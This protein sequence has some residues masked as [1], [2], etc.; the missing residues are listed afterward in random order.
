[1]DDFWK[2]YDSF[3]L[4]DCRECGSVRRCDFYDASTAHVFF[5]DMR[6][7]ITRGD[8][9]ERFRSSAAEMTLAELIGRVWPTV[10]DCDR[11]TMTQWGKLRDAS[12]ILRA[13]SFQGT[14]EDLKR[15]FDLLGHDSSQTLSIGELVRAR[16]LTRDESE[17]L[18]Q[19]WYKAFT[20][21]KHD[22]DS[23]S[24]SESG[25]NAHL[26]LSFNEFCLM[27]QE[28]L[29]EKYVQKED[30]TSFAVYCRSAF[31]ASKLETAKLNAV[32][33][34]RELSPKSTIFS[35]RARDVR[36]LSPKNTLSSSKAG[37]GLEYT[38]VSPKGREPGRQGIDL[39]SANTT[40]PSRLNM[41][42]AGGAKVD[43]GFGIHAL[44]NQASIVMAC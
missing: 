22:S 17:K 26:N 7:T 10:T 9:H 44:Q 28:H 31:Q 24:A 38:M 2:V 39:S 29:T 40:S 16:I 18:L 27:T 13:A 41:K 43:F 11:K 23:D 34:G 32:V 33:E 21:K 30:K 15:I 8:L 35:P 25:N 1:M 37:E 14:R 12:A 3:R 5:L 19:D 6:R 36:A 42:L 4:M 20:K